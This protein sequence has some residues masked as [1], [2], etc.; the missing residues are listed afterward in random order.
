MKHSPGPWEHHYGNVW[1]GDRVVCRID[2][3]FLP[4]DPQWQADVRLIV[5]APTMYEQLK[6]VS[7]YL[8]ASDWRDHQ[9]LIA[10]VEGEEP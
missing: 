8:Y 2:W 7:T 6:K 4:A 5:E 10:R 9:A 1:A 3:R